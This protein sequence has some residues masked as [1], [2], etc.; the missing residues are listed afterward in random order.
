MQLS[1]NNIPSLLAG[2][3]GIIAILVLLKRRQTPGAIPLALM[4]ATISLWSFS[5]AFEVM[6]IDLSAKSIFLKLEF[7]G[8]TWVS[9]FWLLFCL[10]LA[11]RWGRFI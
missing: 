5:Y 4:F 1:L 8:V 11:W 10:R 6:V 3:L 2:L 9:V 7:I